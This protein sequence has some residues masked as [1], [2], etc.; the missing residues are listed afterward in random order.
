MIRTMVYLPEQ[1]HKMIKHLAIE[2]R[3]SMAKLVA[4]AL[5]ALYQEDVDDMRTGRE[6]LAHYM[7]QPATAVPYTAYRAKR[8][9]R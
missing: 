2:R 6:R 9:K 5:E 3:T 8:L 7:A 1:L 4:E